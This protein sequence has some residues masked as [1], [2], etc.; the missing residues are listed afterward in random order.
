MTI[1]YFI[2][3]SIK[4]FIPYGI[5]VLW[6]IIKQR[7]RAIIA[8]NQARKQIHSI[9][10]ND[11]SVLLLEANDCHADGLP[12][13]V[14]YLLDLDYNVD[15]V[16]NNIDSANVFCRLKNEKMHVYI[17]NTESIGYLLKS[18]KIML[19]RHI[20]IYSYHLYYP[21][22]GFTG[23]VPIDTYYS[24][25]KIFDIAPICMIHNSE[26]YDSE[27]LH[28]N[29]IIS[30]VNMECYNRSNPIVVNS[31]YFGHINT[32][33]KNDTTCFIIPGGF[34]SFRRNTNLLMSALD[35][36]VDRN[37]GNFNIIVTGLGT[38]ELIHKYKENIIFAGFL[39]WEH[40]F[41]QIEKADFILP[42]LDGTSNLYNDYSN[43]ASGNYLLSYGFLKPMII[44]HKFCEITGF[45]DDNAII[46]KDNYTL[47]TAMELAIKM[48]PDKYSKIV[49]SLKL[50]EVEIYNKSLKNLE[51]VLS[52]KLIKN[53][54]SI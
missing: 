45:I 17:L 36:L 5:L 14:K 8:S 33:I 9:T 19:Y 50:L 22:P 21:F 28:T 15:V 35:Y 44:H 46:Y 47:G 42:L 32:H 16:V 30:L 43:K 29:K 40:L 52:M 1:G 2:R 53:K 4:A 20:I 7:V 39:D 12:G 26:F 54:A 25:F 37:I 41:L 34:L 51:Y 38:N 48:S 11:G 31:H 27:Y 49:D 6:R 3:K 24:D 23:P 10:I 13:L 18:E